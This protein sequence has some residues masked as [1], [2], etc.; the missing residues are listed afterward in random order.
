M[1]HLTM[2]QTSLCITPDYSNQHH[3]NST[4]VRTDLIGDPNFFR[5]LS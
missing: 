3:L 2:T 5:I 4:K 1:K